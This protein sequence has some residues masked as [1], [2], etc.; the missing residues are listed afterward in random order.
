MLGDS[1]PGIVLNDLRNLAHIEY[2]ISE[3]TPTEND[4]EQNQR[5]LFPEGIVYHLPQESYVW[6][7]TLVYR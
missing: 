4:I 1:P 3:E 2:Y 7:F 6:N 5:A